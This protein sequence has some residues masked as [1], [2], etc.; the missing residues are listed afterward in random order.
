[1]IDLIL[2]TAVMNYENILT[3]LPILKAN[4]IKK[5]ITIIKEEYKEQYGTKDTNN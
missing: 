4:T 1:M 3:L 5:I 2:L